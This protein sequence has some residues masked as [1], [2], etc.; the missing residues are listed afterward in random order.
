MVL[1]N[2]SIEVV[3]IEV[4][5]INV[6]TKTV[7]LHFYRTLGISYYFMKLS[8]LF[9]KQFINSLIYNRLISSAK[10]YTFFTACAIF[11]ISSLVPNKGS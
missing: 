3:M 8:F 10:S 6:F 1:L 4:V 11:S 5:F 7:S 2:V 9:T